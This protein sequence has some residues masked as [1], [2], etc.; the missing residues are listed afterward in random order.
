MTRAFTP[1][2]KY[3]ILV[4]H[5]A[6]ILRG[7]EVV[8]LSRFFWMTGSETK[9]FGMLRRLN[10]AVRCS[11]GCGVWAPLREIDF[12]HVKEFVN[13]GLTAIENGAPLRRTP[14]HEA[15]TS[16]SAAV[17]GKVTR[18]KRKLS[19]TT[20]R[21]DSPDLELRARPR[22]SWPQ[23]SMSNQYW[24]KRFDGSVERRT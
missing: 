1:H 8:R 18:T 5:G 22:R 23:R 19:V 24:R 4:N 17:T 21:N 2:Q 13:G 12:D 3:R 11:C 16:A 14:C 15:K 6:V 20:R 10:C 7:D 9:R